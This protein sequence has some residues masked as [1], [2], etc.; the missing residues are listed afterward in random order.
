VFTQGCTFNCLTCHN[1]HT[2]GRLPTHESRW[3]DVDRLIADIASKARFLSG[4][5]VS[6]GEATLQWEAVHELFQ[7]LDADPK[8]RQLTRLVDSNGDADPEVWSTLSTSMHGAMIDLKALDSDIHLAL[9]GHSNERVLASLRQLTELDRL[10]EVRI[11]VVPGANDDFGQLTETA[12]WLCSL[13]PIPPVVVQGFRREGT[14]PAARW[15]REAGA[16]EL[17]R[18]VSNLIAGGLP[19]SHVS[20]RGV[21][22]TEQG[23]IE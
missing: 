20:S 8:T 17:A 3:I 13:Q 6:G 10:S 9:T 18:V 15:F 19:A 14:R 1:P 5:T 16:A 12:R 23:G 11:L 2:I 22:T 4:V 7:R 21:A